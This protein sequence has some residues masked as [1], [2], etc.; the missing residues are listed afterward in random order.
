[1]IVIDAKDSIVGRLATVVAKKALEGEEIAI[2]NCDQAVYSGNED[3]VLAKFKQNRNR[4]V[5]LKG[6]YYPRQSDAIVKRSIRGMLPYKTQ[7]GKQA[8]A[9]I[10]CYVAVPEN[11][12]K[13]KATTIKEANKKKLPTVKYVTVR[14][15]STYLGGKR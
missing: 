2:V 15:I 10:K 7:R 3:N 5:P 1:M 4:T 9:R 14:Q 12:T 8:F 6:P 13:E 11:L